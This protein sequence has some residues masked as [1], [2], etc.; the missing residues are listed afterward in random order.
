[1]TNAFAEKN[2]RPTLIEDEQLAYSV[3]KEF[4]DLNDHSTDIDVAALQDY[5]AHISNRS[6]LQDVMQFSAQFNTYKAAVIEAIKALDGKIDEL[7]SESIR[8]QAVVDTARSNYQQ[9]RSAIDLDSQDDP[10]LE[11]QLNEYKVCYHQAKESVQIIDAQRVICQAD[12]IAYEAYDRKLE[13]HRLYLRKYV[14]HMGAIAML[15]ESMHQLPDVTAIQAPPA[16]KKS[17][18]VGGIDFSEIDDGLGQLD[19]D[20]EKTAQKQQRKTFTSIY[21]NTPIP[22]PREVAEVVEPPS[23]SEVLSSISPPH[24]MIH[25][26][27]IAESKNISRLTSK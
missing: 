10:A 23:L 14:S 17:A 6:M 4:K 3:S 5:I 2:E 20:Y 22:A 12:R 15:A 25:S 7:A 1:M 8:Q 21:I 18:L 24:L 13:E 11:E 9:T 26:R 27:L 16:M 19:G